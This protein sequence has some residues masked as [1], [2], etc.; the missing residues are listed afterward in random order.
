LRVFFKK[1]GTGSEVAA[2]GFRNDA[3]FSELE[4]LQPRAWPERGGMHLTFVER[5]ILLGRSVRRAL[6]RVAST[7]CKWEGF[8]PNSVRGNTLLV[9]ERRTA[10]HPQ[11]S[12]WGGKSGRA[13]HSPS[14][15]SHER[16]KRIGVWRKIRGKKIKSIGEFLDLLEGYGGGKKNRATVSRTLT[17]SLLLP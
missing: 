7:L 11:N 13:R 1:W 9:R 14:I 12:R 2:E 17:N 16:L 8:L 3:T 4:E 10:A 6:K 15:L 5:G